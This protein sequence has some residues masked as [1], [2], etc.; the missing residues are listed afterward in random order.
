MFSVSFP[1]GC[2]NERRWVASVLFCEFLGIDHEVHFDNQSSVRITADGKTLELSDVFFKNAQANWVGGDTMPMEPLLRWHVPTSGLEP[3]LVTPSIPVIFGN[4]GFEIGNGGARLELDIFGS[5]FFMLSRYEEAVSKQ[6]DRHDRFPGIAS[7]AYREGF[8]DRPIV[9]EYVE[10]L[11]SAMTRLWP[12]LVR[13]RRE[14]RTVISCDVDYPYHPGAISFQRM[15]RTTASR[16]IR[17]RNLAGM[18]TPAL[19]YLSGRGGDLRNDPYY[20][21]VDW[22]MDVNEKAG[23]IVAFNFIPEI[24]DPVFDD[25][26][27]ITDPAVEDM[28]KRI[29][30]RGHQIGIHPGY[31]TYQSIESTVSGLQRLRKVLDH[32]QIVQSVTGGRTHYLRWSTKTPGVWNAAGLRYDSTLGYAD[33]AG[34]RC[35]TCHGYPMFDLHQRQPLEIIQRPLICMDCSVTSYMGY[36]FTD[37]ALRQMDKLKSAVQK[38][39]GNFSL[40]WHNSNFEHKNARELYCEVIK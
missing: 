35:G 29:D 7:V 19:N 36:G 21:M 17:S 12:G 30:R 2:R 32:A 22:I 18:F 20:F 6:R 33:R 10:I 37:A 8:L 4:P 9:D 11:W 14:Y 24:T 1:D 40:L 16:L 3:D 28:L 5:V 34:F 38:V 27:Q 31:R 25:T 13:R 39:R 26:C 15:A 23:N